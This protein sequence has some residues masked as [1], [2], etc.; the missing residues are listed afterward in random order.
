MNKELVTFFMI[1]TEPDLLIADY[2]VKSYR[3]IRDIPFKL[4][5]YSNWVS[6]DLKERYFNAWRKYPFV[7]VDSNEWQDSQPKPQDRKLE[8]P[9]E[10]CTTI[11]D[12]ELKKIQTP[13]VGTVDADFEILNPKFIVTMLSRLQDNPNLGVVSTDY[14]PRDPEYYDSYSKEIICLNERWNTWFCI[15]KRE[16]LETNVSH[17]YYEEILSGPVQRNAWDSCGYLQKSIKDDLQFECESLDK[18]YQ[19]CFIH[20]GAFSKNYQIDS[21]NVGAYRR[22]SV[23]RKRGFTGNDIVGKLIARVLLYFFFPN[24]DRGSYWLGWGQTSSQ[25]PKVLSVQEKR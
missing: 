16:A 10:K 24:L 7:E 19:T 5:I 22:L 23:L 9:F 6:K 4:R 2:A 11:W 20:Y 8:G 18:K 1:V 15:Y 25:T 3:K 21:S 13:Y 12:R 17:S 14:S